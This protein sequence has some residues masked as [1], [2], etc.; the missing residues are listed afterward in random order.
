MLAA[1]NM[2]NWPVWGKPCN[3]LSTS[4]STSARAHNAIPRFDSW[5]D[6][7]DTGLLWTSWVRVYNFRSE[8]LT[9]INPRRMREGYGSH[10]V[11]V[12]LSVPAL[13]VTYLIYKYQMRSCRV[14]CGVTNVCI[15]WISQKKMRCSRDMA[16]FAY[17][18]DPRRFLL[19]EDS[20]TVLD[21][22]SN[23]YHG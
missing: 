2:I 4:K 11:C 6:M 8:A 3:L 18:E 12:S 7:S 15:V 1:W 13:A 16:L 10:R 21:R 22:T 20:P 14:P 9:V 19:T 17:H 5:H 23:E